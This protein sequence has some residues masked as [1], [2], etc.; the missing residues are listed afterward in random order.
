M[1]VEVHLNGRRHG[2][3]TNVRG[4]DTVSITF[5]SCYGES[6]VLI[7]TVLSSLWPAKIFRGLSSSHT[8]PGVMISHIMDT[9]ISHVLGQEMPPRIL[10]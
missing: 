6:Q 7:V 8:I 9:K 4:H 3:W 10:L 1:Y 2:P 5:D